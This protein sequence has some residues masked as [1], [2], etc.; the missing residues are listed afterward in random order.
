VHAGLGL[1]DL[2]HNEISMAVERVPISRDAYNGPL[3][4]QSLAQVAVW[5]GDNSGAI[6]TLKTLLS[7]PGYLSYGILLLDPAWAPLRNNPQFQALV[8]S[9]EPTVPF[10]K[11]SDVKV[12][13][14]R[15]AANYVVDP[16]RSSPPIE[17]ERRPVTNP[18]TTKSKK[19]NRNLVWI[20][21]RLGSNLPG[22]WASPDSP[23]AKEAMTAGN[24]S[25]QNLQ[26]LQAQPDQPTTGPPFR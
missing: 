25:R 7:N 20:K 23:D 1:N 13:P 3:V 4:L 14:R 11:F 22:H 17:R 16:P 24:F 18:T 2:A 6:E 9:Q 5:T 19:D 15:R 8:Q 10:S 26:D 12:V 21:P